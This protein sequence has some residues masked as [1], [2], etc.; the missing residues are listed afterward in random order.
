[1]SVDDAAAPLSY[2]FPSQSALEPPA[3][4]AELRERCPHARISV[5]GGEMTL[6]TRYADVRAVM[7]DPRFSRDLS[8][9]GAVS[10]SA[11]GTDLFSQGDSGSMATS[12]EAHGQWRRMVSRWFTA[13][14]MTALRPEIERMADE[15][16]DVMAEHGPPADL[17]AHLAFPLPVRVICS[18]LGVPD[19][20][21]ER[22][23]HWSHV[24]MNYSR[25]SREETAVSAA[26]FDAYMLGHIEAKRRDPKDDIISNLI[27]Q[28]DGAGYR[29]EGAE[30]LGTAKGLLA[31]GH[32]TT[33]N[34]IGKM[35]AALL[36]DRSRWEALLAD[37]SL[38]RTAV[39]EALRF[40][41]QLG[42]GLPRF[43]GEEVAVGDAVL[44]AGTTA[45]LSMA[46]ANR[47]ATV[48]ERADEMVLDRSPNPHIAFGVGPH[49]CVGQALART[50]MQVVLEVMLRRLPGLELAVGVDELA[51]DDGLIVTPLTELPVRW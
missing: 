46:A 20:D 13:K 45:M 37:R 6:L 14:R 40:D 17:V 12:G 39:E 1:M 30:L 32:E 49:S 29:M 4:F 38:I 31:A 24:M 43:I 50:E 48:F 47:D 44:P 11:D 3:E 7:G 21:R 18:M 25:F 41:A 10:L 5:G 33:A 8:A 19:Q 26:E 2:P 15:L 42:L 22:F 34:S 35:T 28:T 16:V 27:V 9:E 36:A 51:L 23:A